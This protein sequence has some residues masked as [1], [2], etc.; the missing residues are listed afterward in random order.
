M[1]ERY[2]EPV[3]LDLIVPKNLARRQL[4]PGQR[5]LMAL[6]YER[7]YA[8]AQHK[9]RPKDDGSE[10]ARSRNAEETCADLRTT[11][12]RVEP[13]ARREQRSDERAVR[14]VGSSGRAVQQAKAVQ[15]D[16]PDLADEVRRG[17]L[18]LDRAEPGARHGTALRRPD[19]RKMSRAARLS[20]QTACR[21]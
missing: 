16:A 15:R 21:P 14:V 11:G 13:Q 2:T 18:A 1:P 5:A 3:I 10:A 17:E 4:N 20:R 7:F 8:A 19:S 9:G 6:E 12:E